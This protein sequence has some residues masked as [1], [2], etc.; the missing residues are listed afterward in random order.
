MF[1]V[2]FIKVVQPF[3]RHHGNNIWLNGRTGQPK[4]ITP[5]QTLS[6][7][8]GNKIASYPHQMSETRLPNYCLQYHA[9]RLAGTNVSEMTYFVSS[10]T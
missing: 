5:S 6:S 3:T 7:G 1:T 10:G 9:K 2:S 4:N 8:Q